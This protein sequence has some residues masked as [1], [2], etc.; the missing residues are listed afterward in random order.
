MTTLAKPAVGATVTDAE[1]GTTIR[2]IN[3]NVGVASTAANSAIVPLYSTVS[4][5][6]ADETKML[7]WNVAAGHHELRD[8]KTYALIR[9][10][11]I[12]PADIEQV[13][14]AHDRSRCFLFYVSGKDFIRYHVAAAMKGDAGRRSASA[15]RTPPAAT[16][17]CSC[18]STPRASG[19]SAPTSVFVY[20]L[21]TNTVMGRKTMSEN[22]GQRCRP[23]ASSPISG[24]SGRVDDTSLTDKRTLDLK[25]PPRPRVARPAHHRR[26]HLERADVRPRPQ[27]RRRHRQP[28]RLRPDDGQ[29]Q[30]RHRTEDRVS[31]SSRRSHLGARL[32]AADADVSSR[33]Y[34]DTGGKGVLRSRERDR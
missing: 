26:R 18:R 20:D 22:P 19:S 34:G 12:T 3:T 9:A 28:R 15:R 2:R 30:D 31:L 16:I 7:L 11:D 33:T 1:F 17:R 6:N 10:L 23:A 29:V 8:G 27:R 5:W 24:D 4:A 25:E 21:P 14:L 13:S 32:Q